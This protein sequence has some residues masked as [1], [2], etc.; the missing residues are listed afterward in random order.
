MIQASIL[1]LEFNTGGSTVAGCSAEWCLKRSLLALE[2][3]APHH[4][5]VSRK[6]QISTAREQEQLPL[7]SLQVG[8]VSVF[9]SHLI[10]RTR[11]GSGAE[12]DFNKRFRVELTDCTGVCAAAPC[13]VWWGL[14]DGLHEA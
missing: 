8:T 7:T 4:V 11:L 3:D 1:I 12:K 5:E 9:A 6:R 10:R 13:R 2:Q 14:Q